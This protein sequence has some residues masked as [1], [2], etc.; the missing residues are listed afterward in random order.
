MRINPVSNISFKNQIK[1]NVVNKSFNQFGY[2]KSSLGK[3][4]DIANKNNA[5][6]LI[7]EDVVILSSSSG[8][9]DDLKKAGFNFQEIEDVV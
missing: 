3:V 2:K 4:L 5:G 8:I 7:G 1:V 9:K 6:I